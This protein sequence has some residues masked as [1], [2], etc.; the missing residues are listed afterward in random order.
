MEKKKPSPKMVLI[1]LFLIVIIGAVGL[2]ANHFLPSSETVDSKEYFGI[3][4]SSQIALVVNQELLED[5]AILIDNQIYISQPT[6][7]QYISS[8]FY[9]DSEAGAMVYTLPEEVI[10]LPTGEKE[11]TAG[12]ETIKEDTAMVVK[13]KD[14]YYISL[15]FIKQYTDMKCESYENPGRV[16]ISTQT[17]SL[18]MGEATS[19]Y[20]VRKKGGIKSPI[21]TK[22][23]SGDQLIYLET[24]ENWTKVATEDGYIGYVK[25]SEIPEGIDGQIE[26][27]CQGPEYTNISKDYKISMGWH[28]ITSANDDSLAEKIAGCTGMNT[29]SPTWYTLA[30]NEGNLQ[31]RANK[32]YVKQAHKAGLEVWAMIENINVDVDTETIL[33]SAKARAHIIKTLMK[34]AKKYGFDGINVDLE[35]ITED[36][37]PHYLQFIRELSVSCRKAGLV[38]SVDD[39]V[40]ARYNSYYDRKEQAAVVDYVI[41]MGYDEHY[42]GSDEAGSVASLPYVKE[43]IENSLLEVP[44]EKLINALPFY[45]RLWTEPFGSSNI[46]SKALGMDA[47]DAYVK[48]HNM[49]SYWDET[50]GQNVAKTEDSKAQYEIWLEDEQS[51][52]EKMKLVKENDLAGAAF[53]QLGY[54]RDSVWEI[55]NKYLNL[56]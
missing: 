11:F 30:D 41:N 2:M 33:S 54:Q 39:P 14:G 5:K 25:N 56:N 3:E 31:S 52:E 1:V 16:V 49:E 23:T 35:N 38:L 42:S 12:G 21:L 4:D 26:F 45:T 48:E 6:V 13:E 15:D 55:I 8:R 29:I 24:L 28:L 36:A 40:P 22:G 7:N 44:K 46:E 37:A 10:T 51:I 34:E 32:A 43:S 27:N 18:T 20:T 9:M 19:E 50:L 47:A 17:S 53:W